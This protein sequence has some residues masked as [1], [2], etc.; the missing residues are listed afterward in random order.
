MDPEN[1]NYWAQIWPALLGSLLGGGLILG[2]IELMRYRRERKQWKKADQKIELIELISESHFKRWNPEREKDQEKIRIFESGLKG[3]IRSWYFCVKYEISNLTSQ[4][5][6]AHDISLDIS[7]VKM[8]TPE[9]ESPSYFNGYKK[10]TLRRYHLLSKELI[11]DNDFPIIIPAK[12]KIG[13]VFVGQYNYD[14]P[15]LVTSLPED[16]LIK[17]V[18]DGNEIVEST[19][20]FTNV[21]NFWN[22]S[23]I[24]FELDGNELH[25]VPYMEKHGIPIDEIPF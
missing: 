2:W 22:L 3:K 8:T 4:D 15:N 16:S 14:Y 24:K 18:F 13:V 10:Q 11:G 25:W 19:F 5:I 7:Q 12:S 17:I 1:V 20:K 9:K 21:D 6:L 23:E